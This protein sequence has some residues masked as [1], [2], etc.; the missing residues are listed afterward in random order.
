MST[1]QVPAKFVAVCGAA[2]ASVAT[3]SNAAASAPANFHFVFR[4]IVPPTLFTVMCSPH[5]RSYMY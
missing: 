2:Y 1:V 3:S 5:Q 4:M